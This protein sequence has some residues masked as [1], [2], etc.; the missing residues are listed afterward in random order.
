MIR[1]LSAA[2]LA[3]RDLWIGLIGDLHARG[4]ERRFFEIEMPI[5]QIFFARQFNGIRL[6]TAAAKDLMENA[7]RAKYMA[8]KEL[9]AILG[10]S[11]AGLNFRNV[12]EFLPNTDASHLAEFG[13]QS[14]LR[15]YFEIARHS[16]KFA[17]AFVRYKDAE[18]DESVLIRADCMAERIYPTFRCFG[19]VTS[20]ILVTEPR[21]Q[22]LR[23]SFRGIISS[24]SGK[25]LLYLDYAQFEPGILSS[26][27]GDP[28][29]R[30]LY[31]HADLYESLSLE[32]FQSKQHRSICKRIFLAYCY[33]MKL[34]NIAKLL[35]GA[36]FSLE[37]ANRYHEAVAAFFAKFPSLETFRQTAQARLASDG[38]TSSVMGNRRTRRSS[39]PLTPKEQRWALNQIVQ[40]T[41][42]LIFK[43][44]LIELAT[45]FGA[46]NIVLPMHDA[47]LMQYDPTQSRPEQVEKTAI[48]IMVGAFRKWCPGISPRVVISAFAR[49]FESSKVHEGPGRQQLDLPFPS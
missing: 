23:K 5:Q 35:A 4:E 37:E 47:V 15:D 1:I 39:G 12:G 30:A 11:P 7:R 46:E 10:F 49:S 25:R 41:A 40:G 44:A 33:G 24:D 36:D 34:T 19:T 45:E 26:M 9:A 38:F 43:T 22:E 3:L 2:S 17:D 16:S 29:F 6:E 31:E 32:V 48:R 27:A 42:S 8:F 20:R 28:S 13:E 18:C 14:N 21:L